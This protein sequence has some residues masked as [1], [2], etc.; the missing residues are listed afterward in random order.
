MSITAEP[1]IR[2]T[3]TDLGFASLQAAINAAAG[4]RLRIDRSWTIAAPVT[5]P[6]NTMIVLGPDVSITQTT[7]ATSVFAITA[8]NVAIRGPGR[9]VGTNSENIPAVAAIHI[10]KANGV[11]VEGVTVQNARHGLCIGFDTLD[12]RVAGCRFYGGA[13][14]GSTSSDII[15]FAQKTTPARRGL[16]ENNRCFSN[17]DVGIAVNIVS[18]DREVIVTNNFVCPLDSAGKSRVANSEVKRRYGILFSYVGGAASARIVSNN[19]VIGCAYAGIYGTSQARPVGDLVLSGNIA[20]ECGFGVAER[21]NSSGLRAGILLIDAG[22]VNGGL[23]YAMNCYTV[24][25]KIV[26]KTGIADQRASRVAIQCAVSGTT[27]PTVAPAPAVAVHI[28]GLPTGIVADLFVVH[29]AG[30]SGP[31][32]LV[33]VNGTQCG[34]VTLRGR[35]ETSNPAGALRIEAQHDGVEIERPVIIDGMSL[36]GTARTAGELN[37]GIWFRGN[38]HVRNLTAE[39]FDR[40]VNCALAVNDRRLDLVFQNVTLRDCNYGMNAG[41]KGLLLVEGLACESVA[42]PRNG[43][44]VSGTRRTDENTSETIRFSGAASPVSSYPAIANGFVRGDI[45]D[46]SHPAVGQPVGWMRDATRWIALAKL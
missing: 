11:S 5:V 21:D 19:I 20:Q 24:G 25:L 37:S 22:H 12:Y 38:V 15:V 14:N 34:D 31:A 30:A 18:G 2:E 41:G 4:K 10:S 44:F 36:K 45:C 29:G 8:D 43:I 32:V 40:G 27:D 26:D 9:V 1:A 42:V 28:T 16:I 3:T 6:A 13:A 33:D 17:N 46:N 39:T 23:N 35:V 7:A